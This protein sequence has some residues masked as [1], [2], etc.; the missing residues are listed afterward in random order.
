MGMWKMDE[1]NFK[2]NYWWVSHL[3]LYKIKK[4][5]VLR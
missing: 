4:E 1:R 3:K 5:E 2:P